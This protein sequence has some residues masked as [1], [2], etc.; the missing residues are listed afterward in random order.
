MLCSYLARSVSRNVK[1]FLAF[2]CITIYEGSSG[3]QDDDSPHEFLLPDVNIDEIED[4]T[5]EAE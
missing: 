1:A 4:V 2:L 5:D 3:D